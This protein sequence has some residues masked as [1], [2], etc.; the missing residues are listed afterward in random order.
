MARVVVTMTTLPGR[1]D[2]ITRAC[3]SIVQQTR[4]PDAIYLALPKISRRLGIP[5]P[6]MP[7]FVRA[8]CTIVQPETDFGPVTKLYGALALETDPH[9]VI[10]SCDDDIIYPPDMF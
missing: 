4:P 6:P 10:I 2:I 5:Y 8:H 7:E 9:T 1:E 3:E